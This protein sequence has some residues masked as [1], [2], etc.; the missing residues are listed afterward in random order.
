[1]SEGLFTQRKIKRLENRSSSSSSIERRFDI[2]AGQGFRNLT[3][4]M[5][6]WVIGVRTRFLAWFKIFARYR[7]LSSSRLNA[8][9]VILFLEW[10]MAYKE[11]VDTW[12]Q[13][14][15]E[16]CFWKMDTLV[17]HNICR[18]F[19]NCTSLTS[20]IIPRTLMS[21]ITRGTVIRLK[22]QSKRTFRHAK[23][24]PREFLKHNERPVIIANF[25]TPERIP[26]RKHFTW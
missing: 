15:V 17:P 9:A 12:V 22:H 24:K 7:I 14:R 1:M 26:S 4:E 13:S 11:L 5:Q 8:T 3:I 25:E 6:G 18:I 21:N 20:F 19:L 2:L 10:F 16:C 23:S